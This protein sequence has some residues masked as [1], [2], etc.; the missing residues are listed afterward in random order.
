MDDREIAEIVRREID[1]WAAN[2]PSVCEYLQMMPVC[3]FA[4]QDDVG[5]PLRIMGIALRDDGTPEWV[6]GR[7]AADGAL[8]PV[9]TPCVWETA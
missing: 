1:E 3:E 7:V 5:K 9:I 6:V 4:A 2:R 8:E